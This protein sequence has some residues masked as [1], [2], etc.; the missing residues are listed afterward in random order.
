MTKPMDKKE[1]LF[2]A[3]HVQLAEILHYYSLTPE[4]RKA[5]ADA[6]IEVNDWENLTPALPLVT[7]EV[8]GHKESMICLELMGRN[9]APIERLGKLIAI[10][11]HQWVAAMLPEE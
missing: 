11:C 8:A 4:Q 10:K 1:V 2:D 3:F 6:K 5:M 9:R 7:W